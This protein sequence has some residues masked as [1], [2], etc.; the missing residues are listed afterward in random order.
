M[1]HPAPP[2]SPPKP[3]Q[4][5]VILLPI[6]LTPVGITIL[7]FVMSWTERALDREAKHSSDATALLRR[8]LPHA[9]R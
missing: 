6:I 4:Q 2:R 1:A 8:M 7:L 5:T 9:H 3:K